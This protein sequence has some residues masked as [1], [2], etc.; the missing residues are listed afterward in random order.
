MTRRVLTAALSFCFAFPFIS[1]FSA[2]AD[3][4]APTPT[5]TSSVKP[6]DA[7]RP[8]EIWLDESGA[9][10]NAHGAGL[11]IC[12]GRYWLFGEHKVEG[13]LGNSAQVGVHCYSSADLYNWRDEGIALPVSDDPAS[14]IARGCILERPKVLHN[15]KTGKFV[16]FF[17]L[18]SAQSNYRDA[19]TGIA[20]ADQVAGPYRFVRAERPNAGDWPSN[21]A[22]ADKKPL[23]ADERKALDEMFATGKIKTGWTPD[24]PTNLLYR[25]DF[26]G[27]QEARDMTLFQ[28]DDGRAYHIYSS[29][30]NGTLHIAPLTD[31]YLDW[32]GPYA[33]AFSGRYYEAPAIFKRDGKYWLFASDCTG[34]APNAARLAVADNILGP[35]TELGNPCRGTEAEVAKTFWSQSSYVLNVPEKKICVFIGDRWNPKNAIDG[36]YIWLPIQF[37]EKGVPFLEWRDAWRLDGAEVAK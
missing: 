16:M 23:S 12:D 13:E 5:P 19:K 32:D 8:G 4:P 24:Y 28:D 9:R 34:W 15:A 36:R 27:G 29:E 30:S 35:W 17:H 25:A 2:F 20:V 37:D 31:D 26:E 18:E 6:V 22:D 1:A 21:V 3:E 11:L 14:P 7:I 10:I 33:R